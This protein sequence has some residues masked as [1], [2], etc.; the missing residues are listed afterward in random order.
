MNN[1]KSIPALLF[2]FL[3]D[4][5]K[6][7]LPQLEFTLPVVAEPFGPAMLVHLNQP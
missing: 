3:L 2:I 6:V 7:F 1:N 5:V 4:S